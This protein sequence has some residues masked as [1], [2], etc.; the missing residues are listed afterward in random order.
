MGTIGKTKKGGRCG[1]PARVETTQFIGMNS[2]VPDPVS[3]QTGCLAVC[4]VDDTGVNRKDCA[5]V[6][7][8]ELEM[9]NASPVS[10]KLEGAPVMNG[11]LL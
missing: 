7:R 1:I 5:A 8:S 4:N 6:L 3:D 11:I 10:P 9:R 2:I